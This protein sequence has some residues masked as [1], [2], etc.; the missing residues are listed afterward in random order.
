MEV[1]PPT[2]L[3]VVAG[4]QPPPHGIHRRPREQLHPA[5]RP[6]ADQ[7]GHRAARI[8]T[9]DPRPPTP[10]V[11]ANPR[12]HSR[13]LGGA[14]MNAGR[15]GNVGSPGIT[16][17]G[18]SAPL[19]RQAGSVSGYAGS[20]PRCAIRFAASTNTTFGTYAFASASGIVA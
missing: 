10:T 14:K 2:D 7:L 1:D 5:P 16:R 3:P 4:Q 19:A 8:P 17:R 18:H 11:A 20:E 15:Y 13:H 6:A 9:Q 12:G